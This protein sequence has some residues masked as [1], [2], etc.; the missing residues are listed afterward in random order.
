MECYYWPDY[1]Q[2]ETCLDPALLQNRWTDQAALATM[3]EADKK[4][5]LMSKL[6]LNLNS[7][8]HSLTELRN[9]HLKPN[10][11][12]KLNV[13]FLLADVFFFF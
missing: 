10:T 7:E 8:I 6:T 1:V 2:S 3:A 11:K 9:P 4:N 13:L 12:T 5:L